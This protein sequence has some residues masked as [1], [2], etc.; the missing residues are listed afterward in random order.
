MAK[1]LVYTETKDEVRTV[2]SVLS[3]ET[4]LTP[5]EI[6]RLKFDGEILL[7]GERV[8]TD[9]TVRKGDVLK[10]VFPDDTPAEG[11]LSA[12]LPDILYEDEDMIIVNKQAG[13][14]VHAVHGHQDDS[15]G[16]LVQNYCRTKGRN[17]AVRAVGRLDEYVSGAVVFALSRP[18]AARLSAER[19]NG[20]LKKT[21]TAIVEGILPVR[22]GT[23]DLPVMKL[24]GHRERV[25]DSGG[26]QAIT[27][28][29]TVQENETDRESF[30]VL[31][32]QTE[33]GRTHQIRVHMQAIGHPLAGDAL[34]GGHVREIGR[35][36]LHAGRLVLQQP[37]THRTITIDAP[38]P[39]DMQ[40]LLHKGEAVWTAPVPVQEEKKA[41]HRPVRLFAGLFVLCLC[42]AGGIG[43][44]RRMEPAASVHSTEEP[45]LREIYNH[46][47]T[48]F[49]E[50]SVFEYGSPVSIADLIRETNGFTEIVRDIDPLR[51]G[52]Q[53]A[54]IRTVDT[55]TGTAR[56]FT[57][58]ITVEDTCPPEIVLQAQTV[59]VEYG[60]EYNPEG[61][62]VSVADPVDGALPRS[63]DAENGT[64]TIHSNVDTRTPGVYS[65]TVE[66]TD[67][68][69]NRTSAAWKATVEGKK[70]TAPPVVTVRQAEIYVTAGDGYDPSGNV[71]SVIDE[72][73]GTISWCEA[74]GNGCWTIWTDYD[75]D[76]PGTYTVK[77]TALDS[78]GNEGSEQYAIHVAE[79]PQPVQTT[80]P[81]QPD[82][83]PS[84]SPA[85]V[86]EQG[87][88]RSTIEYYLVN[89]MGMNH[90]AACGVLAN[91]QRESSY[92]PGAYNPSGY[93]GI[94]Q[95]GGGRYDRLYS[96]CGENGLSGD[97]L[98]GQLGYLGYELSGSYRRVLDQLLAVENSADG[99]WQSAYIFAM[100]FEVS[101]EY[102]ANAAGDLAR[103]M[104]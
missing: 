52:T 35:P 1:E 85:P 29:R 88:N 94:C 61:N 4:G 17:T 38:L 8:H 21:Y 45:D 72:T 62:I 82:P 32:I 31:E 64:Y 80:V 15:L 39:Q 48:V 5:R 65:V 13:I 69:G 25:V 96:W 10:A 100:Q 102:N 14:P 2:R 33:T 70:D 92:N 95:W 84:E 55:A 66:A 78:S 101:G 81:S 104:Y 23:V 22:E 6:S 42:F 19:Q 67:R 26:K 49:T 86:Q 46:L 90:A 20:T 16:T 3:G 79:K 56:T 89:N 57:K 71:W 54:V 93:Y 7:N 59:T 68:N 77:V 37:F 60:S 40:D 47:D 43:L 9:R 11:S 27:Q 12:A 98:S 97:S 103:S 91:I 76:T 53:T 63:T 18:A 58:E 83:V 34:Y 28:Y 99:A 30:T 75:P 36:A 73:D 24:E 51:T 41:G 74:P 44:Y 50:D 87:D